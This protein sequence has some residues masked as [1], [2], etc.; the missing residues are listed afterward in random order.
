MPETDFGQD[1]A[2]IINTEKLQDLISVYKFPFIFGL[3][4]L[5]LLISAVSIMV[6]SGQSGDEVVFSTQSSPSASLKKIYVDVAGKVIKPGVY[7]FEEGDRISDALAAAGGVSVNADRD[8]MAK[9][10]N[11]AAKLVDGGKI[12]IPSLGEISDGKAQ[13][14]NS[15]TQN[16]GSQINPDNVIGI[17]TGKVNINSATADELDKLPGVGEV[18]AGKIISGRP[19]SNIEDLKNKKIIGSKAFEK[20]KEL[21]VVF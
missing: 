10:L 3:I 19:Y 18:T 4:G 6:K 5:I 15:K 13:S 12:Y 14:S 16:I 11:R 7:E 1:E 20:L 9:N 8:W 2:G 17:T 21:I